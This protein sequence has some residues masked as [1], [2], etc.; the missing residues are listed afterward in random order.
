[1]MK[2]NRLSVSIAALAVAGAG[3]ATIAISTSGAVADNPPAVRV[4]QA[5]SETLPTAVRAALDR[6]VSSVAEFKI[7]PAKARSIVLPSGDTVWYTPG[8]NG[9]CLWPADGAG[10]CT[11][12]EGA[13][14]GKLALIA[15]PRVSSKIDPDAKVQK[16]TYS[17]GPVRVTGV[18]PDGVSKITVTDAAGNERA[19]AEPVDGFYEIVADGWTNDA[20]WTL[21][22]TSG[23]KR[24]ITLPL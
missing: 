12:A 15:L 20:R 14:D 24:T 7:D 16:I 21:S 11:S 4:A 17:D 23:D 8:A 19:T 22:F 1:M 9:G 13:A 2:L 6:A 18:A 10:S 5:P 3:A